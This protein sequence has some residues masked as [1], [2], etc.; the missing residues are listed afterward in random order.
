VKELR[1]KVRTDSSFWRSLLRAGVVYGPEAWIR[2]SPPAIGVLFWAALTEPRNSVIGTLRELRGPRSRSRDL[3]DSAKVF[4][5][6]ASCLTESFVVGADRGYRPRVRSATAGRDFAAA[7]AMGKGVIVATAQTAGWD[8]AGPALRDIQPV[9]VA[10]VMEREDDP[11]ARRMHDEARE[12]A[13]VRVFHAGHDPLSALPLLHHLRRGGV[14]AMK[15][16][17]TAPG[18]R[19]RK[20]TFLGEPWEIPEGIFTLAAVS[21]API[22]PTFTRR[23]GFLEYE[24]VS[25]PPIRLGRRPS[26][27]ELDAA[28]QHLADLLEGF[29]RDNPDQWFRWR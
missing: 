8:V 17:R 19:T 1:R 7:R 29:A 24:F 18:M 15:F 5:N 6:F 10:V 27:V 26:A 20:V 11:E 2:Y 21:G 16:D 14:V 25:S 12:R 23:H 22:L 4:A 9:D 3:V 13:G 28:A